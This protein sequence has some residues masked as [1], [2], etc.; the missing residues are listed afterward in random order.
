MKRTKV[1]TSYMQFQHMFVLYPGS[2]NVFDR[3]G[4]TYRKTEQYDLSLEYYQ[5]FLEIEPANPRV[6]GII[7]QINKLDH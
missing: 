5:K 1:R 7:E 6:L 2:I 3:L 4:D